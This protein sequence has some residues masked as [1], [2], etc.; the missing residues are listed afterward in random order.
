MNTKLF[1]TKIFDYKPSNKDQIS[2]Y[3]DKIKFDNHLLVNDGLS[4][5][6]FVL[7]Y[8]KY[9]FLNDI[10]E[11]FKKEAGKHYYLIDIWCNIYYKGG[12]VKKHNHFDS[13]LPFLKDVSLVSGVYYF[14][15]PSN[16]GDLILDN[17]KT[18][19]KEDDCIL[20]DSKINHSSTSN[21]SKEN[22]IIFSLNLAYN[23]E[24]KWNK[25]YTKSHFVKYT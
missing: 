17:Q 1:E 19:L 12:Y 24:R 18:S 22:R 9:P 25:D 20:F 7:E 16:S 11:K 15:K 2:D 4:T 3:I 13:S 5:Y 8:Q 21:L 14:K 6:N 23:I 10:I